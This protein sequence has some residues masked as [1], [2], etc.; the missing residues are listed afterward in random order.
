MVQAKST[1]EAM[2]NHYED[3]LSHSLYLRVVMIKY[4]PAATYSLGKPTGNPF[5][6]LLNVWYMFNYTGF[7]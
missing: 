2:P 5:N 7:R 1:L 6:S 4:Y 3:C